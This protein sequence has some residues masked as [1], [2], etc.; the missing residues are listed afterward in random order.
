LSL[1]ARSLV[2]GLLTICCSGLLT[3]AQE[4]RWQAGTGLFMQSGDYGTDTDTTVTYIPFAFGRLFSRGRLDL[5]LP[6][7]SVNSTN[8][9]TVIGGKA[10]PV[11]PRP[12]TTTTTE[13]TTESGLG[14]IMLRGWLDV[15]EE[16]DG[17]QPDLDL[18]AKIKMPTASES[19][20][21]GTG[22]FDETIGMELWKTVHGPWAVL[23]DLGYTWTGNP[24]GQELR[25]PWYFALGGGYAIRQNLSATAT[26]GESRALVPGSDN[27]RDLTF[28]LSY[29]LKPTVQLNGNLMFGLSDSSPD[30]GIGLY[31]SVKF[32]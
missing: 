19:K 9:V 20:G 11:K 5:V 2:A 8:Q 21:L 28:G 3:A 13:R 23:F 22:E 18:I 31:G 17:W 26:Y 27:P 30:I 4:P 15:L 1:F 16:T 25:N 7:I 14:D 6:I 32:H 12:G 29:L 10:H 24:D